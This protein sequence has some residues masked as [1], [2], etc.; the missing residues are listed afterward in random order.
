MS[1][2]VYADLGEDFIRRMRNWIK[3]RDMAITPSSWPG[4]ESIYGR[5]DGSGYMETL[6]PPL[7]YGEARDT[8]AAVRSLP[9]RYRDIIMQFWTY[10]GRSLREHARRRQI[11]D[12]T[13]AAWVIKGH[14]LVKDALSRNT[15]YQRARAAIAHAAGA[16]A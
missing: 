13:F 2:S 10:E 5:C 15:A 14:Q 16:G 1:E 3:A 11:D 8:E 9:A 12:K 4:P 7:L 6:P